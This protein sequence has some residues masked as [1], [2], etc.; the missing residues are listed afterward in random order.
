MLV[1]FNRTE[2]SAFK[3]TSISDIIYLLIL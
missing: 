1:T 2:N 3:Q